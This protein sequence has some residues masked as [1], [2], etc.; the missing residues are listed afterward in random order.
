VS[1]RHI[2]I[3]SLNLYERTNLTLFLSKRS[4]QEQYKKIHAFYAWLDSLPHKT[5]NS[6]RPAELYIN[7]SIADDEMANAP[8]DGG[9]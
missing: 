1:S 2:A 9:L 3:L 6:A 4:Y 7:D 8:Q 5:T